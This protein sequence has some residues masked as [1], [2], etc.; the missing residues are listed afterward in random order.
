MDRRDF[1]NRKLELLSI[2]TENLE[3]LHV[4]VIN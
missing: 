3:Y 1:K 2:D 4:H